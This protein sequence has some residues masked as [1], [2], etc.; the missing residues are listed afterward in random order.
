MTFMNVILLSH[1]CPWVARVLSVLSV[2]CKEYLPGFCFYNM[3]ITLLTYYFSPF[4]FLVTIGIHGIL[5]YMLFLLRLSRETE[6]IW[7]LRHSVIFK[8]LAHVIMRAGKSEILRTG[9]ES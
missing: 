7:C 4:T 5:L 6:P 9:Q 2:S 1:S 8:E 3:I